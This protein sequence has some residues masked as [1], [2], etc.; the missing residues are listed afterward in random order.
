MKLSYFR[1]ILIS[2]FFIAL[3]I[4][5]GGLG[6][7]RM[8]QNCSGSQTMVIE[9]PLPGT[10]HNAPAT[11]AE[12]VQANETPKM[13]WGGEMKD[14]S[15]LDMTGLFFWSLFEPFTEPFRDNGVGGVASNVANSLSTAA[16][17]N[18]GDNSIKVGL[19]VLSA[20]YG[21]PDAFYVPLV[22]DLAQGIINSKVFLS[23]ANS[24]DSK[25]TVDKVG[26]VGLILLAAYI[27][28]EAPV[29]RAA[30]QTVS[31]LPAAG[32][33]VVST[34]A[35]GA[36]HCRASATATPGQ[37][38]IG[39]VGGAG[40]FF[41]SDVT[42]STSSTPFTVNAAAG[43]TSTPCVTCPLTNINNPCLGTWISGGV[44]VQGQFFFP[45]G[46]LSGPS[47]FVNAAVNS[48]ITGLHC[49]RFNDDSLGVVYGSVTA[50]ANR[51]SFRTYANQV[52][53]YG[54]PLVISNT[55]T[56]AKGAPAIVDLGTT[57]S[58][59]RVGWP[60]VNGANNVIYTGRFTTS[61]GALIENENAISSSTTA[62][63]NPSCYAIPNGQNGIVWNRGQSEIWFQ[64][65]QSG[66]GVIGTPQILSGTTGQVGRPFGLNTPDGNI[67]IS[68]I[69][70]PST[71]SVVY[72]GLYS[73]GGIPQTPFASIPFNPSVNGQTAQC[74]TLLAGGNANN[75]NVLVGIDSTDSAG[76]ERIIDRVVNVAVQTNGSGS[77]GITLAVGSALVGTLILSLLTL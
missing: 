27:I 28:A 55:P 75:Y 10:D 74:P 12:T 18:I 29:A 66:G 34:A 26:K 19:S 11:M 39:W 62:Q 6:L 25:T 71:F 2:S 41:A 31:Y 5:Q 49:T 8:R 64:N 3:I 20:V 14:A 47:F 53:L 13:P 17:E 23:L 9:V 50:G 57:P 38:V 59:A 76:T 46:T 43:L 32:N 63:S 73:I 44:D 52:S 35:P 15:W 40:Q 69:Q 30:A 54:N 4:A 21:G 7:D 1:K 70:V 60:G 36:A 61:T 37:A 45:N 42:S 51:I 72:G 16:T 33:N 48:A 65:F 56:L 68:V 67:F 77:S 22:V 58:T 24:I